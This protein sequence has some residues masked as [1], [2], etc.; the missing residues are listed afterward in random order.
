MVT[1]LVQEGVARPNRKV[2]VVE[3]NYWVYQVEI[4]GV[5]SEFEL[6]D[7]AN[8]ITRENTSLEL[9]APIHISELYIKITSDETCRYKIM[10]TPAKDVGV[11]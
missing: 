10:L 5:F 1:D 4:D 9:P 2:K 3:G 11:L 6:Y 8:L 7:G